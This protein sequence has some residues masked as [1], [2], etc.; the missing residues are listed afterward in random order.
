MSYAGMIVGLGIFML[1]SISCKNP[2]GPDNENLKANIIVINDCGVALDI[3]MDGNLQ[4]SVEYQ[5]SKIIYSVSLELHELVA[6][7]KGTET[8][9]MSISVELY[10]AINY[11]WTVQSSATLSISNEYGETLSIYVDGNLQNDIDD[12]ATIIFEHFPYGEHLL[13][14]LRTSDKVKVASTTV[15]ID[16]NIE[17]L[18]TISK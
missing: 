15:N 2:A 11:E 8:E 5:A 17:Y 13:E 10:E 9:I 3:Y 6:K 16:E 18:W 14:A 12:Q 7:I 4:F 1:A